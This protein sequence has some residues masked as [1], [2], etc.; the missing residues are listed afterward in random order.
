MAK[1]IFITATNTDIGK[2][3]TTKLLMRAL[4]A[5]GH[6]VGV[7]KPIET[8]VKDGIYPDGD[9]LLALLK[10][11][12]PLAWSL[13]VEDIVPI[14][15]EIPAAPAIASNFGLIDYEKIDRA[16][17]QQEAFCDVLLIEGAGGLFVPLDA[18]F[19]MID[20]IKALQAKTLL[21]THCSLGCINDTL[22]SQKALEA[23]GLPY[24]TLFNCRESDED[25]EKVSAPY[26]HAKQKEILKSSLDIDR[27]CE[28]LYNL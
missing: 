6:S 20:L 8:G 17:A 27:V 11:L 23:A 25:F 14:S 15:Y 21:V 7:I 19:M 4:S 13:D 16:I 2:T 5:K 22:L 10:E 24:A 9:T 28:L 3:Y 26:F 18:N 1:R 12:N